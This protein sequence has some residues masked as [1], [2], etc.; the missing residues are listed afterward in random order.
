VHALGMHY[1]AAFHVVSHGNFSVRDVGVPIELDGQRI[2]TGDILHGDVNG[3]VV[4]PPTA[5]DGLPE[6]VAQIRDRERRVME[7]I[8]GDAF[9]LDGVKS[10]RGY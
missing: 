6:T 2:E 1:Y 5:L 3:I 8:R 7:F 10:G 4:V 9:T